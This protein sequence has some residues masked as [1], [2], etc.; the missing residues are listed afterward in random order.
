MPGLNARDVQNVPDQRQQLSRRSGSHLDGKPVQHT[1]LG[2]F[3]GQ[4]E[5]ADH[6]IHRRTNF[7]THGGQKRGFGPV[8]LISTLL[9]GLQLLQQLLTFNDRATQISNPAQRHRQQNSGNRKALKNRGTI[10]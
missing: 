8:R 9:G 5:H 7:M 4:L 10:A 3:H 6:S 1:L 2:F